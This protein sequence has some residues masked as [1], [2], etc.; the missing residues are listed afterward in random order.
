MRKALI[1]SCLTLLGLN[2]PAAPAR[3][4]HDNKSE[5]KQQAAA[6][7]LDQYIRDAQSRA[8]QKGNTPGAVWF[9]S[10]PLADLGRDLRARFIDDVV[11]VQVVE[12]ATA[13]ATG[14]VKS[15]RKSSLQGSINAIGGITRAK[16]PLANLA[17][18]QSQSALDGAASTSRETTASTVL[19]GRVTQVLP[20]GNLV[21]EATKD[22]LVNSEKQLVTLRGIARPVDLTS[23][24]V[25]RSDQLAQLEVR[26]NGKGVVADATRRPFILYR[27]LMG[28]LPF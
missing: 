7:P 16:G 8:S 19:T 4:K 2:Q 21:I 1:C 24:N 12:R 20:N 11:T 26:I 27:I 5:G 15:Q 23:T 13:T 3:G 9:P 18:L 10:A 22:V 17:N 28:L 25:V 14:A 6:S